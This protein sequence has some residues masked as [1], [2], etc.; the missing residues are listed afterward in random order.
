MPIPGLEP[1]TLGWGHPNV[2][3]RDDA[4]IQLRR[5]HWAE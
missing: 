5:Q 2:L 3:A 1:G 4:L